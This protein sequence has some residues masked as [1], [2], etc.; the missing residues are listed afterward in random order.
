[1]IA[2]GVFTLIVFSKQAMFV[3]SA[4]ARQWAIQAGGRRG[5]SDGRNTALCFF[6]QAL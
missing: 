3:N 4:G 6:G 5:G 1:V 2:V